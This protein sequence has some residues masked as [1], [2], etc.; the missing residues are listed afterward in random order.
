MIYYICPLLLFSK[1]CACV[2]IGA[3]CLL[4]N[5]RLERYKF[6]KSEFSYPKGALLSERER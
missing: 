5:S 4:C 1:Y 2:R 6:F 3:I